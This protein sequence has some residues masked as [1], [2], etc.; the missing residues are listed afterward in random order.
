M[1]VSNLTA[2]D[3]INKY[4]YSL[5]SLNKNDEGG[6]PEGK[7]ST[8]MM[9]LSLSNLRAKF[10]SLWRQMTDGCWVTSISKPES[11]SRGCQ[12]IKIINQL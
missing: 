2:L 6:L 1:F 4:I 11:F 9:L 10:L 3:F 12:K 7:R 8:T 5:V